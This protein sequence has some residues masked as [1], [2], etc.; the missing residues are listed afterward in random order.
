M[1]YRATS[2]EEHQALTAPAEVQATTPPPAP[3]EARP[4]PIL[5]VGDAFSGLSEPAL[6]FAQ[7]VGLALDRL[8][9]QQRAQY[10]EQL[11][12]QWA[13]S[14]AAIVERVD[15]KLQAALDAQLSGIRGALREVL[16]AEIGGTAPAPV[17]E[18]VESVKTGN[19][20]AAI[21]D[22]IA[23]DV[24]LGAT[25]PRKIKVDVV[26]L[27][28]L[29]VARKIER[30]YGK[31]FDF[32]WINPDE[33][34]KFSPLKGRECLMLIQRVPHA[35]KERARASGVEPLMIKHTEGHI[36]HALD[37]LLRG[38]GLH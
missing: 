13:E 15:Q 3:A 7:T 24:A 23:A 1:N 11:A 17:A 35:L 32:R 38:R 28:T 27:N 19:G 4:G 30:T 12:A 10:E 2:F 14:Q 9:V 5:R 22:A 18:S 20:A 8:L 31:S 26:G 33:V 16:I 34:N 37:E 25:G 36:T 21:G 6:V 29:D